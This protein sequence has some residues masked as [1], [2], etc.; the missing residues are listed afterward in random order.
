MIDRKYPR[1]DVRRLFRLAIAMSKLQHPT[2]NAL[3]AET[4]HHKQT[5]I[6]DMTRLREQLAVTIEKDGSEYHLVDW[7]KILNKEGVE[8]FMQSDT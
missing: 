6:D 7:G 8:H 3:S 1:G 5:V 2:L 4:G